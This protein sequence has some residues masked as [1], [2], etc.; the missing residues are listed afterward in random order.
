MEERRWCTLQ[1]AKR[2]VLQPCTLWC[3]GFSLVVTGLLCYFALHAY[4]TAQI[5]A[6]ILAYAVL[7]S[8]SAGQW[9]GFVD[10]RDPSGPAVVSI[11][12]FYDYQN[13]DEVLAGG[14]PIVK[15]VGPLTYNYVNTKHNISFDSNGDEIVYTEYQRFFAA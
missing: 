13:P 12:Y 9:K 1:A 3:S 6:G 8:P 2:L 10:S 14:K 7:T 5:R 11:F 15:T 4:V